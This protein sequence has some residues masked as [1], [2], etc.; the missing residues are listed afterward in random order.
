MLFLDR[1]DA[2]RRLALAA[3][4]RRGLDPLVLALSR[5]GVPVA[6][7]LATAFGAELDVFFV[8]DLPLPG[9]PEVRLGAIAEGGGVFIDAHAMRDAGTVAE[10]LEQIAERES[11]ELA[12]AMLFYRGARE[13]PV[14]AGRTVFLVDDVLTSP[15][16]ALAAVHSLRERGPH[17]L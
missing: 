8:R 5:G 11:A 16:R 4:G 7:V 14:I 2:G 6:E 13:P 10:Q 1:T 3:V 15:G 9:F 17:Q 12:R